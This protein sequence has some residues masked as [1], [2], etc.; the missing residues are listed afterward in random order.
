MFCRKLLEVPLS[1]NYDYEVAIL[2]RVVLL[3]R[4]SCEE[5]LNDQQ[6]HFPPRRH[7][8]LLTWPPA[9]TFFVN[10]LRKMTILLH[11]YIPCASQLQIRSLK[12]L[13]DKLS[14]D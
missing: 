2:G 5:C 9:P 3:P 11:I 12:F 8:P 14:R 6:Y 4:N 10:S 13:V 1:F 7:G